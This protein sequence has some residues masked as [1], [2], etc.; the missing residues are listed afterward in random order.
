MDGSINFIGSLSGSIDE[1]GEGG[2]NVYDVKVKTSS[3]YESVVNEE[4]KIAYIDLSG[5]ATKSELS[6]YVT[7]NAL[8]TILNDYVTDSELSTALNDYVTDSE[9]SSYQPKLTAGEN[10][11]IDPV[12]NVISASGGGGSWDYS[13]SEVNTG[14]KWIDGKDIY[15]CV[16]KDVNRILTDNNWNNNILSIANIS[17]IIDFKGFIG[18]D[19]YGINIPLNY[20]RSTSEYITTIL[21]SSCDNINIRPNINAGVSVKGVN[22]TIYYTKND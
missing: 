13:T 19:G 12:T 8:I 3:Q 2:G 4:D 9:L 6:G 7:S 22:I 16:Y 20:F 11:S 14:Q 21:N 18:L 1:G 17:E 15:C 10:I 5:Y